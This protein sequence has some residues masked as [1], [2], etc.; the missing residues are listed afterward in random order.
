MA[1]I[2]RPLA[3]KWGVTSRRADSL[4]PPTPGGALRSLTSRRNDPMRPLIAI[5]AVTA[6]E[7]APRSASLKE[8]RPD[9]HASMQ[10]DR[11]LTSFHPR[12]LG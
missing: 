2:R 1:R 6:E 8:T 5:A 12:G 7:L 9:P 10:Q 11:R 3:G 4:R